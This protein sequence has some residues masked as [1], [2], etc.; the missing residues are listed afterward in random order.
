[1]FLLSYIIVATFGTRELQGWKMPG[2]GA[3]PSTITQV[4]PWAGGLT[5]LRVNAGRHV[6]VDDVLVGDGGP[7]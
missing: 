4:R 3:G 5:G 2:K 1:M 7:G 6:M